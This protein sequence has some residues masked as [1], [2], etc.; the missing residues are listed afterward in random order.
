M[1]PPDWVL[2]CSINIAKDQLEANK[3]LP[4][5]IRGLGRKANVINTETT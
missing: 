5:L 1:D 3:I 2:H 4:R